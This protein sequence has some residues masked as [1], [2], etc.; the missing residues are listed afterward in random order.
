MRRRLPFAWYQTT[1]ARLALDA[2]RQAGAFV[3]EDVGFAFASRHFELVH[4]RLR[5]KPHNRYSD[6]RS[7]SN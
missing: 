7:G 1:Q 5:P 3:V 6:A 2:H 4:L